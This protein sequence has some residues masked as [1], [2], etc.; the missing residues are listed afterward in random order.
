MMVGHSMA[1]VHGQEY[2]TPR[3]RT[4]GLHK[5]DILGILVDRSRKEEGEGN[6]VSTDHIHYFLHDICATSVHPDLKNDPVQFGCCILDKDASITLLPP[7]LP[8]PP[9][10]TKLLAP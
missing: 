7:C 4:A 1:V 5:G 3:G 6:Q 2:I 9:H 10:V 8:L